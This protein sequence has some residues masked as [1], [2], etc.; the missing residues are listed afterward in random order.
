[1]SQTTG[2]KA[3]L[4]EKSVS[5]KGTVPVKQNITPSPQ[6][7]PFRLFRNFFFALKKINGVYSQASKCLKGG[8][9]S[10]TPAGFM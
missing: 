10:G 2:V 6:S 4:E 8:P 9:P 1:M 7:T 5:V 3:V